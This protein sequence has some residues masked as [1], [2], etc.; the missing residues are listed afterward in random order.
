M[1]QRGGEATQLLRSHRLTA[2]CEIFCRCASQECLCVLR[3]SLAYFAVTGLV[4]RGRVNAEYHHYRGRHR[5]KGL[6]R[7]WR[8]G[9]KGAAQRAVRCLPS[10][11]PATC[12]SRIPSTT[13][14]R[15]VDRGA[16]SSPP[17]PA[18]ARR[19]YSGDGG[20]ATR[21]ALNEPYGMVVDRAGNLYIAD[22]LNRRVRRVD[23]ATGFITTL[24]GTG[25]AAYSGDGGPAARGRFGGAERARLQPRREAALHH[26]CRRQP[27]AG[28]RSRSARIATFAG[29]GAAEHRATAA[30]RPRPAHSAPARSRSGRR[31]G[32]HPRA[33][34]QQPARGRSARPGSSRR[35]PAPPRAA[36]PATAGPALAA[37]FDAPK[38]MAIDRDGCLLIV[39]TENHAIRRIDHRTGIVT[40]LAGG[41]QGP[42]GDGGPAELGRARPAARRGRRPG[43]RDL[44]RRHQ[45]PPDQEG[46]AVAPVCLPCR[47]F[48]RSQGD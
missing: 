34:G 37:V 26:R 24:A 25:E 41:R 42:G 5:R 10:T 14:I 22:R 27:G 23:A 4:A 31:Y 6:R 28:G 20:P 8:T 17:S 45:Q 32:L 7:R 30:R 48:P 3:A 38:E 2:H 40:N 9:G 35:S 33:P 12:I 18:T 47:K 44:Y 15:R 21:A 11:A 46:G 16:A 29:T 39:D 1:R 13:A 43:R 19:A 36:M